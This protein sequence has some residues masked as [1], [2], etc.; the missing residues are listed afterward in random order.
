MTAA[1]RYNIKYS[2]DFAVEFRA[3][4]DYIHYVLNNTSAARKFAVMVD[5]AISERAYNPLAF[6]GFSKNNWKSTYYR[7]YV[8]N[9]VIYYSV[10]QDTMI[11]EHIFYAKR[12]I[13]YLL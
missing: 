7:I 8:N 10:E 2:Y 1:K 11:V 9:Y 3:V 13:S 6:E 12:N 5:Q 4:I